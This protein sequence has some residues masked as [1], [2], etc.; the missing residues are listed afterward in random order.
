MSQLTIQQ[1]FDL[2]V[3]HHQAG[4]LQQAEQLYRQILAQQPGHADALHMLG[5]I[6]HQ[7]G[8]Q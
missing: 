2:A 7:L 3:R 4:H 5:L 8:R 1:A 6:A